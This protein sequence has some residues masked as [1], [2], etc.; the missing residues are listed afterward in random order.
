MQRAS[1]FHPVRPVKGSRRRCHVWGPPT[2]TLINRCV[3]GKLP[4]VV[5][6]SRLQFLPRKL[7]SK[8][9]TIGGNWPCKRRCLLGSESERR[10]WPCTQLHFRRTVL[11]SVIFP[12]T[13][14]RRPSR[15]ARGRLFVH[16]FV[17]LV[18]RPRH[19][20]LHVPATRP[21]GRASRIPKVGKVTLQV[22]YKSYKLFYFFL[23]LQK[24]NTISL[25]ILY[26]I[27]FI[28]YYLLQFS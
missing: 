7:F 17:P 10:A 28:F 13:S 18:R 6:H 16:S 1:Q 27:I 22:T 4:C 19:V 11:R 26:F 8:S 14:G 12:S 25:G 23:L 21:L 3:S 15:L 24:F 9:N 20:W 2:L 5:Q